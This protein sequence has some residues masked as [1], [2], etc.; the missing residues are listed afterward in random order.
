MRRRAEGA[1]RKERL[2]DLQQRR[3][4]TAGLVDTGKMEAS[5]QDANGMRDLHF[6]ETVCRSPRC[7]RLN[8]PS[9]AYRKAGINQAF[10]QAGWQGVN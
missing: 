7:L 9:P 3:P 4:G 10:L 2:C 8:D 6:M 5:W 1:I